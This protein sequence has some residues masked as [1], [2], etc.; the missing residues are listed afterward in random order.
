MGVD[1]LACFRVHQATNVFVV[2]GLG[3]GVVVC[4]RVAG[5]ELSGQSDEAGEVNITETK[6]GH[7]LQGAHEIFDV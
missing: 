2:H 4:F 5:H 6:L 1:K 3:E 7:R